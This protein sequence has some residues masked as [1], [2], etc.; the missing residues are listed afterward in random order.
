MWWAAILGAVKSNQKNTG[1]PGQYGTP[2]AGEQQ[3]NVGG[4][5]ENVSAAAEGEKPMSGKEETPKTGNNGWNS[6]MNTVG[7][8]GQI[9]GSSGAGKVTGIMNLVKGF[10]GGG[11][12]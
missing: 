1:Q 3:S 2:V 9:Q 6:T 7:S 12:K 10:Y 8:I 4:V 5:A 11:A